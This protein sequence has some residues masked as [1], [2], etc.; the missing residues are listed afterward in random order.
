[1]VAAG[2]D[3]SLPVRTPPRPTSS[4]NARPELY[5]LTAAQAVAAAELYIDHYISIPNIARRYG[6]SEDAVRSAFRRIDVPIRSR[7]RA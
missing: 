2:N 1:M 7:R 5:A 3:R 4:P 6:I